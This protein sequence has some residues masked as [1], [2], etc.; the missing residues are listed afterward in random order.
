MSNVVILII[1]VTV[2]AA[3]VHPYVPPN[4]PRVATISGLWGDKYVK[5]GRV[6][7]GGVFGGGLVDVVADYEPAREFA[8][9]ARARS[10]LGWI[11][12]FGGL[13]CSFAGQV[14]VREATEDDPAYEWSGADYGMIFGCT[15]AALVGS[16]AVYHGRSK[17]HDAINVYNA[18][19]HRG[20]PGPM[21]CDEDQRPGKAGAEGC[22]KDQRPPRGAR[23]VVA[24]DA[25]MPASSYQRLT[26]GA[27]RSPR[28]HACQG[29]D[30]SD[31]YIFTSSQCPILG[32]QPATSLF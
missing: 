30:S 13:G 21:G 32:S 12:I 2:S 1:A 17:R 14:R 16:I 27:K 18:W 11:T 26:D 3:C 20:K 19:V 6:H 10:V 8:S 25:P 9:Q 29:R 5:N 31:G 15:A 28:S 7:P 23:C 22:D 4:N 24:T